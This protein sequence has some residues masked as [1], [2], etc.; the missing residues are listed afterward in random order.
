MNSSKILI[1]PSIL[2]SDFG[3]IEQAIKKIEKAGGDWIHLDVMDGH[4]VPNLTFGP[5]MIT[6][7]RKMTH[8]PLDVHLM[9]S[10]PEQCVDSYIQ[11]ESDYITFHHEA[12]VHSHRLIQKIKSAGKK[13][14][15]SIVPSTPVSAI[16]P[17]L[18]D[19]D[20][21]LVMTVN[22]GFGG[23]KFIYS[24]V[25]KIAQL[26]QLRAQGAGNYSIIIDGG[27][28][29]QT[30][31]ICREAGANVLVSGSAF[32]QAREPALFIQQLKGCE[33]CI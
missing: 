13:A 15:I 16:E 20:M 1:A 11:A 14:G 19:I 21:V 2:S 23:Q 28:D 24:C 22:P 6:D 31:K 27:I 26:N 7:I 10:N 3:N 25:N 12:C 9:I 4:F 8:L 18:A 5:K 30:A 17:I 32:F 33:N 29:I